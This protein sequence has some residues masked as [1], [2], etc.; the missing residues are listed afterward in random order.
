MDMGLGGLRE[1]VM[2]REA[3]RVAVHGVA[4]SRSDTTDGTELNWGIQ[5][6]HLKIKRPFF[7]V[8]VGGA[9]PWFWFLLPAL[10]LVTFENWHF[11]PF[12]ASVKR[13]AQAPHYHGCASLQDGSVVPC[14]C[15]CHWHH[16][17]GL[18]TVGSSTKL[19][20]FWV[21][22]SWTTGEGEGG[23]ELG[24][25]GTSAVSGF[26]RFIGSAAAGRGRHGCL[27]DKGQKYGPCHSLLPIFLWLWSHGGCEAL[28]VCTSS[29]P[30]PGFSGLWAQLLWLV[31]WDRRRHLHCVSGSTSSVCSRPPIFRCTDNV[32]CPSTLVRWA[33]TPLLSCG[34]FTGCCLKG[35]NK[36]SISHHC[37]AGVTPPLLYSWYPTYLFSFLEYTLLIQGKSERGKLSE[38]ICIRIHASFSLHLK[39]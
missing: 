35:R 4:K 15:W 13:M 29:S 30:A 1:L 3:W 5:L 12:R 23:R 10:P 21:V 38:C 11:S 9:I 25:A 27:C 32:E 34:R 16:W 39:W 31:S 8:P 22:G 7:C 19:R 26:V 17:L 2:D 14:C 36:E 28:A 18:Q 20:I 24:G 6:V 37:D 33:E